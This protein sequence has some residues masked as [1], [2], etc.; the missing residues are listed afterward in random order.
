MMELSPHNFE[1]FS[2][3]IFVYDVKCVQER[4]LVVSKV[5]RRD[6]FFA[7]FGWDCAVFNSLLE[8]NNNN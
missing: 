8:N 6:L 4:L 3:T 1:T 5:V 7:L 2:V